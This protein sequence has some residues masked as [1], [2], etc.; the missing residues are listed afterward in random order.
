MPPRRNSPDSAAARTQ[1]KTADPNARVGKN[2]RAKDAGGLL[3]V[4]LTGFEP[5]EV[6]EEN[7]DEKPEPVEVTRHFPLAEDVG[8]MPLMEWA[9]ASDV[10]VASADGLRAVYYVLKDVVAEDA[11]ADFR[12]WTRDHK[13]DASDLLDFANAAL[14]ALAGRPTGAASGSSAG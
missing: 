9:A 1:L 2:S 4:P 3:T 10:D 8:I 13:I 7:P 14:E 12:R 6:D 11:W 5:G